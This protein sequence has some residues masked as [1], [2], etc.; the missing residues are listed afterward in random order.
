MHKAS[1]QRAL[2]PS[3]AVL[4]QSLRAEVD[5]SGQSW[6]ASGAISRR[7]KAFTLV[8]LLVVIGIIALL[9]AILLPA[10]NKARAGA[11]T[12]QCLSNLRSIG[13]AM[14]IYYSENLQRPLAYVWNT[15]PN[16]ST[17][18]DQFDWQNGWVGILE[19]YKV[20]VSKLICP[21]ASQP[22][23]FGADQGFGL[24]GYAWSGSYQGGIPT[25]ISDNV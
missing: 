7:I 10:L 1:R 3:S 5:M 23:P 25:P 14:T 20:D 8:E 13:Q 6:R 22:N 11:Q 12:T 19:T 2:F 21:T 9:I 4:F 16:N 15:V 17:P 24:S 18:T